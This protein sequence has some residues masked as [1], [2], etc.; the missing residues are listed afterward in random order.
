[1]WVAGLL[2]TDRGGQNNGQSDQDH[3][4]PV[5]EATVLLEEE[6]L[7][8]KSCLF[9]FSLN[10]HM[11]AY[12]YRHFNQLSMWRLRMID[13]SCLILTE[14]LHWINKNHQVNNLFYSGQATNWTL[15]GSRGGDT[16]DSSRAGAPG[17]M[18]IKT[19]KQIKEYIHSKLWQKEQVGPKYKNVL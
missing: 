2:T 13:D 14:L 7:K 9:S 17:Q 6:D 18:D 10:G 12:F 19:F 15:W 8:G 4:L 3:L 16:E 11:S 5:R 1:M